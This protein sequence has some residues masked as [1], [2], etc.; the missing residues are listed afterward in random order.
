VN[1]PNRYEP[2]QAELVDTTSSKNSGRRYVLAGLVVT[3]M[4]ATLFF[5][6]TYFELTKTGATSF[7]ALLLCITGSTCFTLQRYSSYLNVHAEKLCFWPRQSF[8]VCRFAPGVGRIHGQS[9]RSL[10]RSSEHLAG[11][12]FA[13][14]KVRMPSL[15]MH[16]PNP[17]IKRT[18]LRLAA[19]VKRWASIGKGLSY[20]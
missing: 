6:S 8:L 4:L 7:L 15:G 20:V 18:S 2:P 10:A 12:L 13:K 17:S 3:Q 5:A 14:Q 16:L 1:S 19:Y 9:W 11:G